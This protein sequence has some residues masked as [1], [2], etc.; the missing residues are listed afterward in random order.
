[1]VSAR[2]EVD[3]RADT[4]CMGNNFRLVEDSGVVCTVNGFHNAFDPIKDVPIARGATGYHDPKTGR[5]YLIFINQ[6]LFFGDKMDHSLWNPNQIRHYHIPVSDDIYDETREF[7]I[8]HPDVFLPFETEGATVFIKSFRPTKDQ[9]NDPS[10][11]HI[12]L[13]DPKREWDP[14]KIV[15]GHRDRSIQRVGE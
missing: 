13:T 15:M 4:S 14:H 8:N 10:Y 5:K 11:I 9:L 6:G 1:M 12:E 7:G 2:N 3:N